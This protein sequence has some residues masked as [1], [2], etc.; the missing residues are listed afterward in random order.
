LAALYGLD[1]FATLGAVNPSWIRMRSPARHRAP[2]LAIRTPR[3]LDRDVQ[4][5]APHLRD[6]M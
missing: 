3:R 1:A 2:D 5:C 6:G 4:S